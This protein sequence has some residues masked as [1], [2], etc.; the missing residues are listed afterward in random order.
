MQPSLCVPPTQFLQPPIPYTLP[1]STPH[2]GGFNWTDYMW[3]FDFMHP[4]DPGMRVICDM[5]VNLMQQTAM[6]LLLHPYGHA[7]RELAKD[8][9]PPPMYPGAW[10]AGWVGWLAGWL[11]GWFVGV[12]VGWGDEE[13]A[14]A[15][16]AILL[17]WVLC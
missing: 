9:L 16:V 4:I 8:P 5:V 3:D 11:V 13:L 6:S 2:R 12:G 7:D 1:P 14:G 10:W 17:R 15:C